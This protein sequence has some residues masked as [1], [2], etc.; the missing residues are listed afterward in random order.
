MEETTQNL[1][2]ILG[3]RNTDYLGGTLPYKVLNESGDW[4]SWLPLEEWQRVDN[5]DLQACVTFSALNVIE[6]LYFFHTGKH[7][8]FSDRFTARM[9]G[10]TS[11]GNWLWK[12]GDSIRKD[13]LVDEEL[14]PVPQGLTWDTYYATPQIEVINKAKKFLDDWQVNYEWIDFTRESLLYHIKQAPIQVVFPNHAVMN[15][16]NPEGI[17]KYFDS[18]APFIKD[19]TDGFVSALKYVMTK[20]NNMTKGQKIIRCAQ[21]VEGYKDPTG[22]DYWGAI[23]DSEGLDGVIKHFQARFPDKIKELE[24]SLK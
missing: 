12:V 2:V 9:S 22:V 21:A 3:Q 1:G 16:F 20:K 24:D 7:Q 11:Q 8:N 13:G 6:T 15:F 19:R 23:I 4:T 18:Y 5:V 14:W 10:T 17:Y